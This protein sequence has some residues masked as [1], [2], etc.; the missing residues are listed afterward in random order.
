MTPL[1]QG[2]AETKK[3]HRINVNLSDEARQIIRDLGERSGRTI[4]EVL[5]DSF[6][7]LMW[8]DR[9]QRSGSRI[10]VERDGRVREVV[11]R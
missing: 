11:F 10:L 5:R 3:V 9:E 8:F 4:S 1:H 6:A 7:L 2:S